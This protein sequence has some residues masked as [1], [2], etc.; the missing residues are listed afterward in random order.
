[1]YEMLVGGST[2]LYPKGKASLMK[3]YISRKH[4]G[5]EGTS[6]VDIWAK[7]IPGKERT[8]TKALRPKSF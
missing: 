2:V 4:K 8:H 7:T 1:M 5:H 6:H 3:C